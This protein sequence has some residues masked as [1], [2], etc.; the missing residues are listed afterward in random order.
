MRR[1]IFISYSRKDLRQVI[2]ICDDIKNLLGCES[3]IDVNGIES[4]EQFVNIIIKAIDEA[5]IVLFMVSDAS[6]SSEYTKKEVMYA[7]HIG[8]KVVPVI[9]DGSELSGWFLFES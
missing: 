7:K 5:K 6:M 8:K 4:G 2:A 3:W 1:D 9:L